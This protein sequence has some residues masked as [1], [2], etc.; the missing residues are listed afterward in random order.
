MTLSMLR[1]SRLATPKRSSMKQV[2]DV[3]VED[4]ARQ[5][6]AEVLTRPGVVRRYW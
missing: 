5:P 6:V 2:D 1:K 4:L 3:L